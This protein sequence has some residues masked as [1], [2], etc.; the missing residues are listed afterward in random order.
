MGKPLQAHIIAAV[1][2]ARHIGDKSWVEISTALQIHPE[3]A[4]QAYNRAKERAHSD[5][6]LEILK[7]VY[8]LKS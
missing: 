5:E 4:R 3:S 2:A 8:P 1:V 6:I 7:C